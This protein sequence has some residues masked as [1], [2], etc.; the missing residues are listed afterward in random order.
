MTMDESQI[1]ENPDV[2][3]QAIG[4]ER[5]KWRMVRGTKRKFINNKNAKMD[6]KKMQ[7]LSNKSGRKFKKTK[8]QIKQ[9]ERKVRKN[10]K[11]INKNKEAKNKPQLRKL[12]RQELE[13]Y[14]VK[15]ND[16]KK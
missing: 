12:V 2:N 7:Q 1:E 15:M 14:R 9:K 6:D 5:T 8:K 10:M 16:N 11:K 13:A 3:L 4:E